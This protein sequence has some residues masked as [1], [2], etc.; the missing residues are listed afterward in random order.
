MPDFDLLEAVQP[1]EGW[2]SVLGI[3]EGVGVRQHMVAT[4]AAADSAIQDF[5]K[6][7]FN[8][9]FG[10]AKFATKT[11]RTKDNVRS[12]K[13][14]WLDIDCG[15]AK[16]RVNAK[17]GR[18]DGYLT[19]A[20]GTSAL[21]EFCGLV[22]LPKPIL[23]NSGRGVHV[24]WALAEDVTRA[25]WEPVAARLHQLCITHDF[26]IDPACFEVA[27][28]L[29]VPG[30]LN[31]KDDPPTEVTVLSTAPPI[32]FEAFASILGADTTPKI[33]PTKWEKEPLTP[34]A[35][36]LQDN[37]MSSFDKIM[38]R[39][40]NGKGC[41][42]ILDCYVHRAEISEPRW[43]DVLSVAKFCD[44]R[45]TAIH[46]IS[47]GY[48]GYDPDVTTDKIRHIVG[49]HTCDVFERN[50]PG[51]CDGCA[52]KGKIKSPIVLG[53]EIREAE[54]EA[55]VTIGADPE[56][57]NS[58][59]ETYV[60]PKYPD[61]YFRGEKGGIYRRG[62]GDE[63]VPTLVYDRDIY[64]V[65][66]MYDPVEFDVLVFRLHTTTDGVREF[67]IPNT[68]TADTGEFRKALA[69]R[70]VICGAK[71]FAL[72]T[73]YLIIAINKLQHT[74]KA[75][76]MRLQF[77][78]AD[79][80]SKFIVG[81]KE[82]SA[83]GT[84]HSPPSSTTAPIA[85]H[86]GTTGSLD[87]WKEV[88]SLYGRPGLE[89]HAF[90]M[91]TAFGSPLFKFTGQ[92]GAI[93]N[94]VHPKSGTGKTTILHMCNSVWGHPNLLCSTQS[95]KPLA[96]IHRMGVMGNLPYTCDEMT[97]TTPQEFSDQAYGM[98]QGRGRDRMQSS[99]NQ[100]RHNATTWQLIALCSS[101][102]SFY[103][104]L[105]AL[106]ASPEGELM[107]L[108]EFKIDHSDA[109]EPSFAKDM[110]D[111]Q[112]MQNYGHAGPIYAEW[113]VNNREEAI[114]TLLFTQAKIDK[115]LKLTPRERFWSAIDA[116]NLA[117]GM[118]AKRLGLLDWDMHSIY[119]FAKEKTLALREEVSPPT[120][121]SVSVLGDYIYRH[122]QNIL[123]VNDAVDQR[124][125]ME[126][127]PLREPKGELL[128]RYEPDTKKLYI[129]AASFKNDCIKYQIN[130]RDT[131]Q[132]L[133]SKGVFIKGDTVRLSKGMKMVGFHGYCLEFDCSNEEFSD[134]NA[135]IGSDEPSDDSREG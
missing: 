110:F 116:S 2:F 119:Q 120:T 39:S 111:H 96:K 74:K 16:A 55:V 38:R 115:E 100:L 72:L 51:G 12:L 132:A 25:Q 135:F 76:H 22:G 29:R 66:R 15:E 129:I 88:A 27:R 26:Y 71:Q 67:I 65:K 104:K 75:E 34:L 47:E 70:G 91:L 81:D 24:Y 10:V 103:E 130:Y 5:S 86:I 33:I 112:L 14:F 21:K 82:I 84:F 124:S 31:Y 61:P 41:P 30:T 49:P 57:G 122:M 8:V 73:D 108:M 3:K 87:K 40:A 80:D 46:K 64:V 44:D 128:I 20:A 52:F 125:K 69:A 114:K 92:R 36:S 102:A 7:Q 17:T 83:M 53:R 90:A 106:K 32:E 23:V 19:Q 45:D 68:K 77:G 109:I 79:N 54:E 28:V 48:A 93:I 126:L 6:N 101:N 127:R 9:Y 60:I 117:G 98:S 97:N 50:N 43:F 95:D 105:Y 62:E 37:N 1:S 94:V 42:Q 63:S 89:A 78:W 11:N 4:R 131:L 133:A 123:V 134:V 13:A 99:T 59:T 85:A 121:D 113:L 58:I 56:D 107:R 18:P 118:I 35:Q